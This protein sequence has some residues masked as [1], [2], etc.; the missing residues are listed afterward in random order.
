MAGVKGR[1][2]PE[3]AGRKKG[4]PN[5][6]TQDLN[7]LAE[8]L[9]VNPIEILLNIAKGDFKALGY[10]N[11][12]VITMKDGKPNVTERITLD[13]RRAA[14][15]DASPYLFAQR[16]AVE[17]TGEVEGFKI[18]VMDYITKDEKND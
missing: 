7:D 13:D 4:T 14:A 8:R 9:G 16:K 5:K 15:K 6:R 12:E 10:E 18:V 2:K 3:G 11:N 1:P 17:V